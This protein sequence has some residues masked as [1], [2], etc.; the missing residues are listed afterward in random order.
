MNKEEMERKVLR[1]VAFTSAVADGLDEYIDNPD[2]FK[3]DFLEKIRDDAEEVRK[4]LRLILKE[5][6]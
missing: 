6:K 1:A 3:D 5:I 4:T 2:Q